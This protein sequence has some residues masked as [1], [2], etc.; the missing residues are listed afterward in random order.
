MTITHT[1]KPAEGD[2]KAM[3]VLQT[4]MLAIL[5]ATG[6]WGLKTLLENQITLGRIEPQLNDVAAKQR[7]VLDELQKLH[8]A[9][10]LMDKRVSVIETKI[11]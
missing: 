9:D 2:M 8:D 5:L 10:M 3:Q 1:P 11:K 4:I 7:Y 6:G